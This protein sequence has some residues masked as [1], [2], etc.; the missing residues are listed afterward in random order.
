[1]GTYNFCITRT[2]SGGSTET[3]GVRYNVGDIDPGKEAIRVVVSQKYR[4]ADTKSVGVYDYD[5]NSC[6]AIREEM[7]VKMTAEQAQQLLNAIGRG[8]IAATAVVA[9]EIVSGVTTGAVE[10]A[11][12]V[13]SEIERGIRRLFP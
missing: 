2:S 12:N 1:M 13:I 7:N 9:V 6:G 10:G 3:F 8:D 11:K 5:P 4:Q